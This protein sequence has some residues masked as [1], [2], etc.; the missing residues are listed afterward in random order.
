MNKNTITFLCCYFFLS[1][2]FCGMK[3]SVVIDINFSSRSHWDYQLAIAVNGAIRTADTI[4]SFTNTADCVLHGVAGNGS[5]STLAFSLHDVT[6]ESDILMPYERENLQR[7]FALVP[8]SF[9][10]EDR[11]LIFHDSLALPVVAIGGWDL[12]RV[13]A[14]VIPSIPGMPVKKGSRWEREKKLPLYSVAGNGFG[15]LYQEFIV[16]SVFSSP[17]GARAAVSWSFRYQVDLENK[18]VLPLQQKIP[19]GGKGRGKALFN[20][21]GKYLESAEVSFSVPAKEK[22][23]DGISWE[24]TVSLVLVE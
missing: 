3:D 18:N 23:N 10:L 21:S 7:Q 14:R 9:N 15:D 4:K 20:I 17:D 6:I 11:G 2:L 24:E 8:M 1:F 5:T 12:Y 16:D 22:A 13:F 19:L